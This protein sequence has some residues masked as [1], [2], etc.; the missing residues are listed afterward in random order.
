MVL[1]KSENSNENATIAVPTRSRSDSRSR[2]NG[3]MLSQ[4][5]DEIDEQFQSETNAEQIVSPD[6]IHF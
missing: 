4:Q 5:F 1:R 6:G 3:K 2:V